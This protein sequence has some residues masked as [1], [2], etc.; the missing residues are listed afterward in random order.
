MAC[1]VGNE[2]IQTRLLGEAKLT[3]EKAVQLAQSM[4]TA[5]KNQKDF[6]TPAVA[7]REHNSS[8]TGIGVHKVTL[9][10]TSKPPDRQTRSCFRCGKTGHHAGVCRHKRHLQSVC[11]SRKKEQKARKPSGPHRARFMQRFTRR[12]NNR[13][14]IGMLTS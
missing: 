5:A 12:G 1:G 9:G 4:E 2:K 11:L 8:S 7:G 6:N 10:K 13:L 3:Y 14:Q